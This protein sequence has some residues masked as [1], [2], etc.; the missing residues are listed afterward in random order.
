MVRTTI[1][2]LGVAAIALPIAASA[3]VTGNIDPYAWTFSQSQEAAIRAQARSRTA[4]K[5]TAGQVSACANRPRFRAQY[6]AKHPKVVKLDQLC[7]QAGL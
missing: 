6:G 7:R 5:P 1:A 2:I 3:S 4:P